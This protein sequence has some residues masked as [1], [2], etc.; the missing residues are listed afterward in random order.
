MA[1][2]LASTY[3]NDWRQTTMNLLVSSA[4]P[5]IAGLPQR[6]RRRSRRFRRGGQRAQDDETPLFTAL[7]FGYIRARGDARSAWGARR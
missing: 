5:A 1:D 4:H 6:A 2:A 7:D 3:G